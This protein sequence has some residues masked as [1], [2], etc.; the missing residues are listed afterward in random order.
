MSSDPLPS[1]QICSFSYR[2]PKALHF[3][4]KMF[5]V[6][7]S[8]FTCCCHPYSSDHRPPLAS[9]TLASLYTGGSVAETSLQIRT[10]QNIFPSH[11]SQFRQKLCKKQGG[12]FLTYQRP[13]NP[14]SLEC[15]V[16]TLVFMWPTILKKCKIGAKIDKP[17]EVVPADSDFGEYRLICHFTVYQKQQFM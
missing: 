16:F 5:W 4:P 11:Q 10:V 1:P 14:N 12:F 8:G 2:K 6:V 3:P 15:F 7:V 17:A 13:L 9:R